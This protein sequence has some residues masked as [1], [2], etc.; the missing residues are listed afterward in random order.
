MRCSHCAGAEAAIVRR[1]GFCIDTLS[2]RSNRFPEPPWTP[3]SASCAS[4]WPRRFAGPRGS[5][6]EQT[7]EVA[8][9]LGSYLA[10]VNEVTDYQ[11]YTGVAS[12][13]DF[14]GMVRRYYLRNGGYLGDVRIN[15]LP[16]DRRKHQSHE[17][18]LPG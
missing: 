18:A 3:I 5:T 13:M 17:I 9:A 16:K 2:I 14:N 12:P 8:R 11:T 7:D 15:L 1:P 10:T 4:T 6:L